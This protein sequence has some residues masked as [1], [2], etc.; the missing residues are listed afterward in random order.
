MKQNE[1]TVSYASKR[2]KEQRVTIR[3]TPDTD[4]NTVATTPAAPIDSFLPHAA[5]VVGNAPSAFLPHALAM[6]A[7]NMPQRNSFGLRRNCIPAKPAL[8]TVTINGLLDGKEKTVTLV[9]P[10]AES[11]KIEVHRRV[12]LREKVIP[13]AREERIAIIK[14]ILNVNGDKPDK[15]NLNPGSYY[16][17]SLITREEQGKIEIAKQKYGQMIEQE[18]ILARK[19]QKEAVQGQ[20]H[21]K[22]GQILLAT[23]SAV[24]C[25]ASITLLCRSS[26]FQD[27]IGNSA[28]IAR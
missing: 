2:P 23:T 17:V 6:T 19:E 25:V 9:N 21:K 4:D 24:L 26:R 1:Y 7:S 16:A 28:G 3:T 12:E 14:K 8:Q 20:G 10:N 5:R 27:L 11:V 22:I 13:N 15:K 18:E